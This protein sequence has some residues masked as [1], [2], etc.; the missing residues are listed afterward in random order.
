MEMDNRV[1]SFINFLFI[2][3]VFEFV[4]FG[5]INLFNTV[6]RLQCVIYVQELLMA[7]LTFI[8]L[9]LKLV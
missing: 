3:Y 2:S 1:S 6:K 5:K 4:K 8:P 7:Y 9:K